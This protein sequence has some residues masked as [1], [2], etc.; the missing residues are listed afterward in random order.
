[1]PNVVG[2][3]SEQANALLQGAGLTIGRY[4]GNPQRTVFAQDPPAGTQ[5][6]VGS[7]IS[8]LFAA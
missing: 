7:G 6:P 1:V 2:L 4:A 5:I 3:T 8:I